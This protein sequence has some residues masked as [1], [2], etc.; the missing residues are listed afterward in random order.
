MIRLITLSR[1]HRNTQL[2][3]TNGDD[4]KPDYKF[5]KG[6]YFLHI[7]P[8]LTKTMGVQR[9]RQNDPCLKLTLPYDPELNNIAVFNFTVI[10]SIET[11]QHHRRKV[12]SK[13]TR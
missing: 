5:A 2:A 12:K 11:Q 13:L 4:S 8:K 9:P 1:P 7:M 6:N 10:T 3:L